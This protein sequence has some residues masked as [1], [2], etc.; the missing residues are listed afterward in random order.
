MIAID[1]K[2]TQ[3]IPAKATVVNLGV[4]FLHLKD[5]EKTEKPIEAVRPNTNPIKDFSLVLPSAIITIPAVAITIEIQTFKEIFSFKNKKA[6]NAVKKGIAAKH[7]N[8]TAALVLVIEYIKVII[9]TPKPD[10]PM[11]PDK[12]IFK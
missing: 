2:T 11:T 4:S 3:K 12:P 7:S 1:E 5:T 9:A 8:V 10:P 6:N